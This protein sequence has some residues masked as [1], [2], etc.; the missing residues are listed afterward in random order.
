M[1]TGAAFV[2]LALGISVGTLVYQVLEW[3][4]HEKRGTYDEKVS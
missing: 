3:R 4:G 1:D 2:P